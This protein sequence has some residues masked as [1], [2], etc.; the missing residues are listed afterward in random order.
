MTI[1]GVLRS[2][3]DSVLT[4]GWSPSESELDGGKDIRTI[5]DFRRDVGH[6]FENAGSRRDGGYRIKLCDI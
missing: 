6:H 1:A 2:N 5:N 4:L 3:K